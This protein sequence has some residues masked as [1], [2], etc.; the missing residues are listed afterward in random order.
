MQ[1][2]TANL[3]VATASA[4]FLALS[5]TAGAQD[6]DPFDETRLRDRELIVV[7]RKLVDENLL[8]SVAT[9]L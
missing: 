1:R 9:R 2:S 4:L 3:R 7:G 5:G 6:V 8:S